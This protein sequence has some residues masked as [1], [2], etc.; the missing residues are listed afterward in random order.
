ML[1]VGA[2]LHQQDK[3]ISGQTAE[4]LGKNQ[5]HKHLGSISLPKHGFNSCF[6]DIHSEMGLAY[7][8][9]D[10][11]NSR[12]PSYGLLSLFRYQRVCVYWANR[13]PIVS[14]HHKPA[15][16]GFLPR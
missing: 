11:P 4:N 16:L 3:R 13:V 15:F 6:A 1:W 10:G 2:A 14:C 9:R 8:T 12:T 7:K 5:H